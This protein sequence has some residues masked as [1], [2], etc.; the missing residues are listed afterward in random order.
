MCLVQLRGLPG[1]HP[2]KA[3]HMGP[4][5]Q[6]LR[7]PVP[8]FVIGYFGFGEFIKPRQSAIAATAPLLLSMYL[9]SMIP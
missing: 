4:T 2:K 6:K 8:G 7:Q 1:A 9:G 3:P 5:C